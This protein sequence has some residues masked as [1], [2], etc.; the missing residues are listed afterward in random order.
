[1]T[2]T[3]PSID[4]HEC[5][6]PDGP[7]ADDAYDLLYGP[8]QLDPAGL[9]RELRRAL[10]RAP[11]RPDADV[12]AEAFAGWLDFEPVAFVAAVRHRLIEEAQ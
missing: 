7:D 10:L 3:S 6:A 2:T 12:L 5:G 11:E 8:F 9:E 4:S 1:M